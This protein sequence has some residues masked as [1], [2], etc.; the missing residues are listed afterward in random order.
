MG[1]HRRWDLKPKKPGSGRGRRQRSTVRLSKKTSPAGSARRKSGTASPPVD[2]MDRSTIRVAS[3][4]LKTT[5][6]TLAE[7]LSYVNKSFF[8]TLCF[9]NI[10]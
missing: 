8:S 7:A 10:K 9:F 6:I 2:R 5:T 3:E 1:S 4:E